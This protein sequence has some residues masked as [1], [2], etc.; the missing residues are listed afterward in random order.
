MATFRAVTQF[1]ARTLKAERWSLLPGCVIRG[2]WRLSQKQPMRKVSSKT[3]EL[4][5]APMMHIA[6][7]A[8]MGANLALAKNNAAVAGAI[9]V[10]L[11][12]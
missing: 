6:D 7:G 12:K 10:A 2:S 5:N 11:A 9:A 8:T 1:I 3:L 4:H